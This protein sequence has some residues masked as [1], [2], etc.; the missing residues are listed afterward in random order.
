MR[1]FK[2]GGASINSAKAIKNVASILV[3]E[4]AENC[5]VVISAMGKMT[6]AFE[7]IIDAYI[8]NNK[9]KL[10]EF[11]DF[12]TD[13]HIQIIKNLFSENHE[14]HQ[15]VTLLYGQLIHF[16]T[17]NNSHEYDYLYDQIVCY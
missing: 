12:T 6:N 8:T 2:F 11:I 9:E 5:L 3:K 4:D 10:L 1:V 17:Q 14:I 7:K 15:K 16:L 13:Y